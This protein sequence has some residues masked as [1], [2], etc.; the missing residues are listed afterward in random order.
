MAESDSLPLPPAKRKPRYQ[1]CPHCNQ[2]VAERTYRSHRALY[3][4]DGAGA[5][6]AAGSSGPASGSAAG[7]QENQDVSS[8]LI[9]KSVQHITCICKGGK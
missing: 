5:G 6:A 9:S 8:A 4:S 2:Q 1:W 3:F 7:D